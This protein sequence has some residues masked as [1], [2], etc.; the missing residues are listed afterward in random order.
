M[1]NGTSGV[2]ASGIYSIGLDGGD[3]QMLTGGG[4][5]YGSVVADDGNV[6]FISDLDNGFTVRVVA[7]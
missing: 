1:V 5:V 3:I 7:R 4:S 6:Y 2:N